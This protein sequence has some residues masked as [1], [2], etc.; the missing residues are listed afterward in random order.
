MYF[1][2][3]RVNQLS[4]VENS[5]SKHGTKTELL[6]QIPHVLCILEVVLI[7]I[8]YPYTDARS[9]ALDFLCT[10]V[11]KTQYVPSNHELTF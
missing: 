3:E 11:Y 8:S 5:I 2:S 4:I 7:K 6:G 1:Q 10:R 9:L